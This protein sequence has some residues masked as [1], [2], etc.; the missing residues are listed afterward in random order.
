MRIH[1][2]AALAQN[3]G[4][5][6]NGSLPWR[7]YADL[8]KFSA[9]TKSGTKN[10]IVMGRKTWESLP[11][12]PLGGRINFVVSTTMQSTSCVHVVEYLDQAIGMAENFGCSDLWVIGGE[13][14]YREAVDRDDVSSL[15]LTHVPH[16]GRGCDR[17][18][19]PTPG[20]E[21]KQC[22]VISQDGVTIEENTH[23]P[24]IVVTVIYKRSRL[25]L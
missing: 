2:V 3:R 7:C 19:P 8:R 5:G 22:E 18:F 21:P 24:G 17:F 1:A 4:I 10:A 16:D 20:W 14:L 9:T 25:I 11:I 13:R 23:C 6:Q 15:V 12:K